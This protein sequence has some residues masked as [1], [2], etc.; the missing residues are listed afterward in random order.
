MPMK[1]KTEKELLED[2]L[3]LY[4]YT[5]PYHIT[6]AKIF[7]ET[8]G[9][10]CVKVGDTQQ[11]D[12]DMNVLDRADLRLKQQ[13]KESESKAKIHVGEWKVD[14]SVI[15][16]DHVL[17][18]IFK[19]EGKRPSDL[20]GMGKEWF[21][22]DVNPNDVR[23][24]DAKKHI[25]KTIESFG[26]IALPEVKLRPEQKR[27]LDEA[28]SIALKTN[29]NRVDIAANLPP[30]FGK[31]IWALMMFR[32]FARALNHD[33]MILPASWLSS[34]TSFAQEIKKFREFK[35][36]VFINTKWDNW[37]EKMNKAYADG[38]KVV[39]AVSLHITDKY[40]LKPLRDIDNG[41][42]FVCIDEG[43]YGAWTPNS[44]SVLNY[45]IGGKKNTGKMV[46]VPMSG[47]NIARMVTG[48]DNI[49]GLVQSTY[50]RLEAIQGD[51]IKRKFVRLRLDNTDKYV[52]ELTKEGYFSWTKTWANVT[53]SQFFLTN[54]LQGLVAETNNQ[55]YIDLSLPNMMDEPLNVMMMFTSATLKEMAKFQKIAEKARPNY[56]IMLVNGDETSNRDAEYEVKRAIAEARNAGQ[57]GVI[58]ISRAMG[59]RS[60]S[61][62][63]VQACV[64][65]YDRGGIDPTVQKAARC[66]TP[67]KK[68]NGDTKEFGYIVSCSIDPNR[69]DMAIQQLVQEAAIE[70]EIDGE[71]M[72]VVTKQLLRNVSILDV[73]EYGNAVEFD[74][75][76]LLE[77]LTS[78]EV[79]QKVAAALSNPMAVID[80]PELLDIVM[81]VVATK[82][83]TKKIEKLLPDAKNFIIHGVQKKAPAAKS[84]ERELRKRIDTLVSSSAY[85]CMM[86]EGRTYRDC[87]E[88]IEEPKRFADRFGA[89]PEDVITLLDYE[90]LPEHLLDIV[91]ANGCNMLDALRET[92]YV[93]DAINIIEKFQ[94]SDHLGEFKDIGVTNDSTEEEFWTGTIEADPTKK[95]LSVGTGKG[96][97]VLALLKAG[98][99]IEN[100]TILDRSGFNTLW[101]SAG[102]NVHNGKIE[103]YKPVKHFDET[104]GNPPFSD[105]NDSNSANLDSVFLTKS[106]EISDRSTLIM[107]SKHFYRKSSKFR[108]E[109]FASGKIVEIKYIDTAKVFPSVHGTE[110]C[111]I[112]VDNN[113]TGPSRI[114]FADGVVKTVVL[115][116]NYCLL[117]K[118]SDY[119]GKPLESNM[120]HRYERGELKQRLIKDR[121]GAR[122]LIETLAFDDNGN[123]VPVIRH[124]NQTDVGAD[125]HGVVFNLVYGTVGRGLGKV[126]VKPK[127]CAIGGNVVVLYTDSEAHSQR[128]KEYLDSAEG[129]EM[130]LRYR[131]SMQNNRQLFEQIPDVL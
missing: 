116:E 54:F 83:N 77:E 39:I 51:M 114:V 15:N 62:P 94:K 43:D 97:E 76:T 42:K 106:L 86:G 103:E 91:V 60:F 96:A 125:H 113:H 93:E 80:D 105:R 36:M 49:D 26:Q 131:A 58:I 102:F 75:D 2:E 57:D 27:T 37:V 12:D 9:R 130:V 4:A 122:R 41:Y 33:T 121:K 1:V 129:H 10:L 85:V 34:Q 28:V 100:I 124:T 46:V 17:H 120:V 29:S 72:P 98:V 66:L 25:A 78:S 35:N 31:T 30:R 14:K 70:S 92:E 111:V 107:R 63:E 44:R 87:L 53:K 74:H 11:G 24:E 7:G 67:G 81:N 110:V 45:I 56:R 73:D 59:S 119:D 52:A 109:L 84:I 104:L 123:I 23:I 127:D 61:V 38:K 88:N 108:K 40:K 48:S 47:T 71:P 3:I 20:D 89:S 126:L 64:L 19:L 117:L 82:Q 5:Y 99:P 21:Y 65:C 101:E 95:Y 79:V 50:M 68:W 8:P 128:V 55:K 6:D 90:V 118:N 22:F 112:T 32:R 69:D 18:R 13:G 16:K 115:D